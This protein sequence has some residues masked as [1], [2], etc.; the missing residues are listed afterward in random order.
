MRFPVY[1]AQI[2]SF[3]IVS[4]S[5]AGSLFSIKYMVMLGIRDSFVSSEVR[6]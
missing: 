5:S 1:L 3:A 6:C 4:D 2:K